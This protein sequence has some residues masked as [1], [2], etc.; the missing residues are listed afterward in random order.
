[1]YILCSQHKLSPNILNERITRKRV[2]FMLFQSLIYIVIKLTYD[3]YRLE[4]L[5]KRST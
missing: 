2:S 5:N 3:M 1:M 4:M